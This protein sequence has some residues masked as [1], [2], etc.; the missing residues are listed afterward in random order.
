M[1]I[2]GKWGDSKS[3][4]IFAVHNPATGEVVGNIPDGG[5]EDALTAVDAAHRAFENWST[6]T[7]YERSSHLY[8]AHGLM[9]ENLDHLPGRP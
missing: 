1:Y 9:L 3:G 7:A 8:A 5:S 6:L 2:D 4:R